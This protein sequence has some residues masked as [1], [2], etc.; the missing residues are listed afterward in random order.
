MTFLGKLLVILNTIAA[1]VVMMFAI[2]AYLHRIDWSAVEYEPG[3]TLDAKVKELAEQI[4][5]VQASN[6]PA[7]TVTAQAEADLEFRRK[8]IAERR[9]E[10]R[11]GTF[12]NQYSEP[13]ETISVTDPRD[14]PADPLITSYRQIWGK[15][16]KEKLIYG[17]DKAPIK[18]LDTLQKEL[19]AQIADAVTYSDDLAKSIEETNKLLKELGEF[20]IRIERQGRIREELTN[21]REFLS[22]ARI[23]YDEQLVTLTK[24]NK[25]LLARL[26]GY[27]GK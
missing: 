6:G 16:P 4:K 10:A 15:L 13:G 26:A 27:E 21:E 14:N 8:R 24:R 20:K 19:N 22:D 11:T 25:Q 5:A 9:E 12:Y 3:Y 7:Q 2:T 18:G 17:V 1:V 23:N